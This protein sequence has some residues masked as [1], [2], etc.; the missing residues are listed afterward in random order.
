[1]LSEEISTRIDGLTQRLGDL[2]GFL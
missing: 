2:E 1:M